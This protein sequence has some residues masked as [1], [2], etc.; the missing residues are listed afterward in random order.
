MEPGSSSSGDGGGP[1][2]DPRNNV[3]GGVPNPYGYGAPPYGYPPQGYGYGHNYGPYNPQAYGQGPP[4]QG[5]YPG[6]GPGGVNPYGPGGLPGGNPYGPG[7]YGPPG[8]YGMPPGSAMYG[9][10]PPLGG[11]LQQQQDL[12]AK[13]S[14]DRMMLPNGGDM[15]ANG[16]GLVMAEPMRGGN[17]ASARAQAKD[18]DEDPARIKVLVVGWSPF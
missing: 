16:G 14:D 9:G 12:G 13:G 3:Y 18:A 17:E 4:P 10:Q 1:G 2:G 7:P 5:Y 8:N 6:G 15:M 11:P